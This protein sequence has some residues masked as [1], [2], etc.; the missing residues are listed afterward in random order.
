MGLVFVALGSYPVVQTLGVDASQRD[1]SL[2]MFGLGG[3]AF[4]LLGVYLMLIDL[5][6][7]V[8]GRVFALIWSMIVTV[9]TVLFARSGHVLFTLFALVLLGP[10]AVIL[11]RRAFRELLGS[12]HT[13]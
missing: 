4:V 10:L 3:V 9:L 1:G 12:A 7:R 8:A 2:W 6:P 11:W 13:K 5:A